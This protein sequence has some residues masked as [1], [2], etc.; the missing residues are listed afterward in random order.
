MSMKTYLAWQKN[1]IVL[2]NRKALSSSP[3]TQYTTGPVLML[4]NVYSIAS[5]ANKYVHRTI[6]VNEACC[7]FAIQH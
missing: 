6:A 5:Y 1:F 2:H 4:G 7:M 3:V